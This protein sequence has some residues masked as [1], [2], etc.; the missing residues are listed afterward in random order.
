[1]L[2]NSTV[3]AYMK[4]NFSSLM[5]MKMC[6]FFV[7][8]HNNYSQQKIN[9]KI[10]YLKMNEHT[11]YMRQLKCALLKFLPL[12]ELVNIGAEAVVLIVS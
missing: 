6:L 12:I 11:K 1:M 7:N 3:F 2:V 9:E 10:T 5:N 8:K 4:N